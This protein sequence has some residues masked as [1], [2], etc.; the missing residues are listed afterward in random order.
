[1]S[2]LDENAKKFTI[3]SNLITTSQNL[4]INIGK[5][6]RL[7]N[8]DKGI[9]NQMEKEFFKSRK[10]QNSFNRKEQILIENF[11]LKQNK[12]IIQCIWNEFSD[13]LEPNQVQRIK[14]KDEWKA[15]DLINLPKNKVTS[16]KKVSSQKKAVRFDSSTLIKI[17][18]DLNRYATIGQIDHVIVQIKRGF[19]EIF[20]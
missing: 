4:G 11:G 20:S 17:D 13:I 5:E 6:F 10:N 9:M 2:K 7:N 19:P 3:R 15:F 12:N 8:I 18:N 16:I 1:M 14:R